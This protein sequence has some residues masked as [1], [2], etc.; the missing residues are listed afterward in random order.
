MNQ[1]LARKLECYYDF[2]NFHIVV[3]NCSGSLV[4]IFLETMDAT[5]WSDVT[6]YVLLC[7]SILIQFLYLCYFLR[8]QIIHIGCGKKLFLKVYI[9]VPVVFNLCV[10]T[11]QILRMVEDEAFKTKEE[12]TFDTL[13]DLA[14][15]FVFIAFLCHITLLYMRTYP[16]IDFVDFSQNILSVLVALFAISSIL[17]LVFIRLNPV[18]LGGAEAV[19]VCVIDVYCTV[20]FYSFA[21]QVRESLKHNQVASSN[22]KTAIFII[23]KTGIWICSFSLLGTIFW[24]VETICVYPSCSNEESSYWLS[25]IGSVAFYWSMSSTGMLW[26]RMKM[27]LDDISS[28]SEEQR[29]IN[30]K[31]V[32]HS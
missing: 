26:M 13:E 10:L 32:Q 7:P 27:K 20:I 9:A 22:P 17:S 3:L 11:S 24:L 6:V 8:Y 31:Q 25:L 30:P 29:L 16:V 18:I 2:I 15:I 5:V 12:S 23:S 4:S 28:A 19:L 21:K 1:Q 14:V